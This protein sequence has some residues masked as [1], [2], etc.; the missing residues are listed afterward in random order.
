MDNKKELYY[1]LEYTTTK[2]DGEGSIKIKLDFKK[3]YMK[4]TEIDMSDN[5]VLQFIYIKGYDYDLA[6]DTLLEADVFRAK[7]TSVEFF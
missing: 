1:T 4:Y 6:V 3:E 7:W 2:K 5:A